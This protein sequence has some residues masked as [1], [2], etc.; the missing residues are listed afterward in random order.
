MVAL[1]HRAGGQRADVGT[2]FLLGHELAAL[3]QLAHVGLGQ[4]VQIFCLQ[5]LAAEVRE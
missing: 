2:A 4:P 1:L 5:R 3:R